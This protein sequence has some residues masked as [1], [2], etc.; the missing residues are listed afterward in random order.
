MQFHTSQKNYAP[1]MD[2]AQAI[3]INSYNHL[4]IIT[5]LLH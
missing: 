3:A 1:C 5:A 4:R 2:C